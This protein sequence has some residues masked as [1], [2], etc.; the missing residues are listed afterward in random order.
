[1]SSSTTST[2]NIPGKP[3]SSNAVA[4]SPQLA[5]QP[6][7]SATGGEPSRRAGGGS[8]GN[9]GAGSN[10]RNGTPRNNQ[11]SRKGHRNHRKPDSLASEEHNYSG[12]DEVCISLSALLY[13]SP[14]WCLSPLVCGVDRRTVVTRWR[15]R[16]RA[17]VKE[18]LSR[19]I[20]IIQPHTHVPTATSVHG[21]NGDLQL[22]GW[23]LVTMLP[24]KLGKRIPV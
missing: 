13:A 24:T 17:T 22:G 14:H 16:R 5:P 7:S 2:V 19:L 6:P 9:A 11:S 8:R 15:R 1:M 4:L 3:G 20:G 10:T 21:P 12:Y 18:L 23:A